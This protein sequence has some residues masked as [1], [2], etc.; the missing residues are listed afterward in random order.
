M[1]QINR[2]KIALVEQRHTGKWLAET[3]GKMKLLF[4]VGVLTWIQNCIRSKIIRN[5]LIL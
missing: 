3:L 4:P 1:E 5:S 2:L